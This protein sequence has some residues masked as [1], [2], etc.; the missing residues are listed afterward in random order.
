M[1]SLSLT[2]M[3]LAAAAEPASRPPLLCTAGGLDIPGVN[4]WIILKTDPDYKPLS[5]SLFMRG[6]DFDAEW[7]ADGNR[8]R[9]PGAMIRFRAEVMLPA[10]PQG[11]LTLTVV[12]D[13]GTRPRP[14]RVSSI[15]ASSDERPGQWTV[16]VTEKQVPEIIGKRVTLIVSDAAGHE[17]ARQALATPPWHKFAAEVAKG[18]AEAEAMR[19][20]QDC[21][22]RFIE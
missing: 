15:V 20:R 11:P 22:P 14:P 10:P 16:V 13:P 17:I 18:A 3:L 7:R 12:S 2:M 5:S 19:V 8:P 4:A 6:K 1:I 21:A 9:A